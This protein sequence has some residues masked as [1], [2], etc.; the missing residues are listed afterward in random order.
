MVSSSLKLLISNNNN[1]K[2]VTPP[3]FIV[4]LWPTYQPTHPPKKKK[5]KKKKKNNNKQTNKKHLHTTTICHSYL[6]PSLHHTNCLLWPFMPCICGCSTFLH[7]EKY[8]LIF[9]KS[10][11]KSEEYWTLA[12]IYFGK[13]LLWKQHTHKNR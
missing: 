12:F 13:V 10:S 2:T 11:E 4:K 1:N 9:S 3:Y 5:K 8:L 6:E 7:H